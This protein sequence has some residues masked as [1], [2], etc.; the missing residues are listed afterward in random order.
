[1]VNCGNLSVHIRFLVK[2]LIENNVNISS[3]LN[4]SD[5][6]QNVICIG[7]LAKFT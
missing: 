5:V 7:S 3:E 4:F 6:Y 1:M 2:V